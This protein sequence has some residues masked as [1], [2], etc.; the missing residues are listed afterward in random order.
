MGN[1]EYVEICNMAPVDGVKAWSVE[2]AHG[3]WVKG[4]N[5]GGSRNE[6]ESFATN[7]QVNTRSQ[8]W[9]V[10]HSWYPLGRPHSGSP[11]ALPAPYPPPGAFTRPLPDS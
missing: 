7:S 11:F 4:V 1:F 8:D 6:L 5:A 10:K 2:C 3:S 9:M